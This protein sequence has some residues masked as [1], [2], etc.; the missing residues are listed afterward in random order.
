MDYHHQHH[1]FLFVAA[2]AGS[3]MLAL[4][5]PTSRAHAQSVN[6]SYPTAVSPISEASTGFGAGSLDGARTVAIPP[7][8]KA[9][10]NVNDPRAYPVSHNS[11]TASASL[12]GSVSPG[13][14]SGSASEDDAVL[15]IPQVINSANA[16]TP[17]QSGNVQSAASGG[18]EDNAAQSNQ[19]GGQTATDDDDLAATADQIGTLQDYENQAGASPLG[20]V[21]FPPGIRIVQFP[22]VPALNA[23]RQPVR[24]P[25]ATSAII[26]PPTSSGPFPSTSPMLMAPRTSPLLM[27]PRIGTL[28][29]FPGGGLMGFRR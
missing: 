23:L 27:A 1:K 5:E 6:D 13:G 3:V 25:V 20:P 10:D 18:N 29:A 22:R 16:A 26:L 2:I 21:F 4:T 19:A 14:E 9:A 11:D 12:H 8:M 28:G 24:I 17:D 15:E 7:D